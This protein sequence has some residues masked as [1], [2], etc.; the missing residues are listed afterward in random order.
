MLT[1]LD[2]TPDIKPVEFVALYRTSTPN[3]LTSAIAALATEISEFANR[4]R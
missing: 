4:G 1:V 3:P 2:T